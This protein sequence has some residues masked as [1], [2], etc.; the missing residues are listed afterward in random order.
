MGTC[1]AND[2]VNA[3]FLSNI[4]VLNVL[5]ACLLKQKDLKRAFSDKKRVAFLIWKTY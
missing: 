3:F 2:N 5:I 4:I 1:S